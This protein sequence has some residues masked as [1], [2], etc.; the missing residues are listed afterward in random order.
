MRPGFAA[1]NA[2]VHSASA[3]N[4]VDS[5]EAFTLNAFLRR[6]WRVSG[7]NVSDQNRGKNTATAAERG[8]KTESKPVKEAITGPKPQTEAITEAKPL[9]EA[10]TEPQ[11]AGARP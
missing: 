10:I 9:R 6:R 4:A 2:R 1:Q 8:D 11:A 3:L 7:R 5:P